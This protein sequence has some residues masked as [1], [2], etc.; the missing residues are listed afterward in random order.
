MMKQWAIKT[1]RGKLVRGSVADTKSDSW[2]GDA[3]YHDKE[4]M[5]I[6]REHPFEWEDF[7]KAAKAKGY[8]CVRVEV[9]EIKDIRE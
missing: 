2:E 1:P 7:I 9:T 4:F 8:T 5:A 6:S 3:E